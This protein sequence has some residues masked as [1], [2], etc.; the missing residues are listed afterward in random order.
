MDLIEK[1]NKKLFNIYLCHPLK[2]GI[3]I[4][5]ISNMVYS[6]SYFV[7]IMASERN[8]TLYIGVTNNLL[9]RIHEHKNNIFKGFTEKYDVKLLVYYEIFEDI[10]NAIIKE[11]QLKKWNRKWKLDLIEKDNPDW[12]DLY[13]DIVKLYE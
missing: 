10:K 13:I 3:Q 11:K 12:N 5:L 4:L 6:N 9:N 7:Y 2:M 1:Y 8:G